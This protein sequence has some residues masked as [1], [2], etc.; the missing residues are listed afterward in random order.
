MRKVHIK[1]KG[2]AVCGQKQKINKL[3]FADKTH[4]ATCENCKRAVRS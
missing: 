2:K 1:L 4:E 3:R